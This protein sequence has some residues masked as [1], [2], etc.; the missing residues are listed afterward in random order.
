MTRKEVASKLDVVDI[1]YNAPG[2]PPG[3]KDLQPLVYREGDKICVMEGADPTEGLFG[4]GATIE[5]AL[6][7]FQ[8][9]YEQGKQNSL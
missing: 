8:Q 3:V 1:D 2:I 7:D 9:H 5:I 6:A 4:C